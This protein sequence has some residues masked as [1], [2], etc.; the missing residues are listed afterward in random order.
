MSDQITEEELLALMEDMEKHRHPSRTPIKLDP[1]A[2][3]INVV[4]DTL[5]YHIF[6]PDVT[7]YLSLYDR[8]AVLIDNKCLTAEHRR[9]IPGMLRMAKMSFRDMMCAALQLAREHKLPGTYPNEWFVAD[10]L[11]KLID[12]C[13]AA[14][15]LSDVYPQIDQLKW[16]IETYSIFRTMVPD[17]DILERL[18]IKP[19]PLVAEDIDA[20]DQEPDTWRR[21]NTPDIVLRGSSPLPGSD[22]AFTPFTQSSYAVLDTTLPKS[23]R[24]SSPAAESDVVFTP[25]TQS[26]YPV[27]D[28]TLLPKSMRR[29]TA[30][31]SF[32]ATPT[33]ESQP[34]E[35]LRVPLSRTKSLSALFPP[36]VQREAL[37][38]LG[39]LT[40]EEE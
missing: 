14:P 5:F 38:F 3:E 24:G 36:Q 4:G 11:N 31:Q 32:N 37:T 10:Y 20:P 27:L 30:S 1:I 19:E 21:E 28:T 33:L 22:A 23:T 12:R 18:G 15:H 29:L 7:T 6:H 8:M 40:E 9:W 2:K 16:E 13:L 34:K 25:F 26:S 35:G 17:E 39:P